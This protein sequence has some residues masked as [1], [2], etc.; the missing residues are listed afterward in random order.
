[1][2]LL[3][4]QMSVSARSASG[5]C[6]GVLAGAS[7]I[8]PIGPGEQA[9]RSLLND[10]A[11]LAAEAELLFVATDPEPVDLIAQV[12]TCGLRCCVR[13]ITT[14]PGRAQQMNL[15]AEHARRPHFWF[16]HADSRVSLAGL[17]ALER[18][19]EIAPAALHYFDLTFQNDGPLLTRWNA[20]GARL[21]SRYLGLPFGDQGFCLSR[22]LFHRL[23]GFDQRARYGEDH[24]LIW[25]AHRHKVPV[26]CVGESIATSARKYR[27]NGWLRVTMKHAWLAW[28]QAIPEWWQWVRSRAA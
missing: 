27:E 25:S 13:W 1:M 23:D 6:G 11:D 10:L 7:V 17:V 14:T 3:V 18:S 21:R 24:L 15:G 28:R 2:G 5:A 20:C 26:R 4:Q 16:L 9:W 22:E 19:L 8:V 12:A